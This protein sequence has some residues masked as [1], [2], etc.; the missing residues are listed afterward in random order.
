MRKSKGI[1][2]PRSESASSILKAYT[3]APSAM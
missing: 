3:V 2:T 1:Y